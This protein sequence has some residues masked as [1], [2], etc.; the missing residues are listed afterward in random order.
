MLDAKLVGFFWRMQRIG[1]KEQAV[2][3][4]GIF[5]EE[6]GGLASAVGM[7]TEKYADGGIARG[8]MCGR[9]GMF[10]G[11]GLDRAAGLEEG[12]GAAKTLAVAPGAA[13]TRRPGGTSEA[14]RQVE[15]QDGEA[16]FGESVGKPDEQLGLAIGACAVSERD[17]IAVGCGGQ[18]Q[19]AVDGGVGGLVV[20]RREHG[21]RR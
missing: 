13:W 16:A 11:T 5:G 9:G 15:A 18:V 2:G 4:A 14:K 20:E 21:R 19:K 6:H 10:R 12:G 17:G 3:H 8:R 7:A 1:K